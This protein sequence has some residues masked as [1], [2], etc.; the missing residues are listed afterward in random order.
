MPILGGLVLLI[1]FS[2]AFHALK[3]GRPYWWIFIIMGFPVMGCLIYYF[4]EVFPNSR[5]HR[6][7]H[8]AARKLARKLQP[9]AELKRRAAELEVCGSVDNRIALAEECMEHQMHEEAMGLYESCLNGAFSTDGTLLFGLARASVEAGNWEKATAALDRLKSAAPKTR[10]LD[11]RLLEARVLEGMELTDQAL[12][13]YRSLL[14]EFVGLEARYRYGAMLLRLGQ[15]EAASQAFDEVLRH[16]KRFASS[17]E[18]EQQWVAAAKEA[19][20]GR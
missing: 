4:V 8:R 17:I 9:D 13:A 16:A 15:Q 1:Q 10:P 11:A 14:P 18:D 20:A 2:F 7:A 12:A 19:V 3:T 5:E 6:S